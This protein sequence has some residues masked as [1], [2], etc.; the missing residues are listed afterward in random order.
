M[1]STSGVSLTGFSTGGVVA[2]GV[3]GSAFGSVV[4]TIRPMPMPPS[5]DSNT[6]PVV[7]L[8]SLALIGTMKWS[9]RHRG[10]RRTH[11]GTASVTIPHPCPKQSF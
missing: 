2:A 5:V 8:R 1:R 3:S 11:I 4:L 7:G 6:H 10:H 9:S